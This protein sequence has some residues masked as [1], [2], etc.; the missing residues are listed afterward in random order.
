M[1]E[2]F[3]VS[4]FRKL[5]KKYG[6]R[7]SEDAAEALAEIV[8]EVGFVVVEEALQVA[9]EKKRKTI[10]KEDIEEAKKRLW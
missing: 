3:P 8:E 5:L 7:V 4:P 10:R 6:E 9:A 2:I 1:A